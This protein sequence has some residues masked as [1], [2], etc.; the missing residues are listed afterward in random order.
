MRTAEMVTH[1]E[2]DTSA[3]RKKLAS[4]KAGIDND[5]DNDDDDEEPAVVRAPDRAV[6]E[7]P[8]TSPSLADGPRERSWVGIG[9]EEAELRK[10]VVTGTEREQWTVQL[11]GTENKGKDS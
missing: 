9:G 8:K 3:G 6:A 7:G 2:T 11:S 5:D 1:R 10:K 4:G